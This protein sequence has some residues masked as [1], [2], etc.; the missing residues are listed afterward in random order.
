[1]GEVGAE[2]GLYSPGAV[3]GLLVPD[4]AKVLVPQGA[5]HALDEAVGLRPAYGPARAERRL[6]EIS[7]NSG[8]ECVSTNNGTG[9]R[10]V[11][12]N[13]W[14]WSPYNSSPASLC[15]RCLSSIA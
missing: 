12:S 8:I 9:R 4:E 5:V 3:V 10:P 2:L 11:Y 6:D 13:R 1:M 14:S 15:R 7:R